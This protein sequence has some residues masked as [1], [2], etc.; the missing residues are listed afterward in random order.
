MGQ[1]KSPS[2]VDVVERNLQWQEYKNIKLN[3]MKTQKQQM[4]EQE[5]TFKPAISPSRSFINGKV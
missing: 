1:I 3:Q 5:C 2:G 4:E